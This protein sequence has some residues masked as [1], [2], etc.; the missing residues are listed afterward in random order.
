METS[1]I[2]HERNLAAV[3]HAATF[4]KFFIPFGNF[5]VPLVLWMTNKTQYEF[6]DHNGKQALNFQISLLLY[7]IVLG[8]L[9]IP[10][11]IGFFPD[12]L[13]M[14]WFGF[15]R[16]NDY[17]NLNILF[18]NGDFNFGTWMLPLGIAGL[19]QAALFVVNIVYTII[20]TL[21]TNE[22]QVFEYPITIK[23]IN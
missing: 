22:G 7:S 9:T 11:V 5:I 14:G 12:I 1:L 20:A 17:N 13:E 19:A 21:R 10:F 3:I 2:K 16:L 23:F 4:S 6:V 15:D 8:F 18:D